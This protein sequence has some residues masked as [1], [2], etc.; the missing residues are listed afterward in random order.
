MS[1][2]SEP[3][4]ATLDTTIRIP[5]LDGH[6]VLVGLPGSG[7]T[8]IGK[9]VA[10]ILR[11]PFLDFD[12]EI[13]KR[14]GKSVARLFAE[15]GEAAFRAREVALTGELAGAPPM[16]L[17]PGGGWI[18]SSGVIELIRPPALLFHLRMSPEAA[19]KRVAKSRNVRPLLRTAN[20]QETMDRLWENRGTLYQQADYEIDVE[21]L[22]SQRVAETI[23]QLA[24]TLT[25]GLG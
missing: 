14:T 6:L 15:E 17:S 18:T 20:P 9:K 13:E 23:V 25:P 1:S 24:R 2:Q 16:V 12:A 3:Q 21:V 11:C 5:M 10:K 7:K 4:D 22:D 19:M 8:T